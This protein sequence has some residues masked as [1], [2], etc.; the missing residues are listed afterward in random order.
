MESFS[1]ALDT[2]LLEQ[3]HK[4]A[5]SQLLLLHKMELAEATALT[6]VIQKGIN[7]LVFETDCKHSQTYSVIL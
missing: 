1:S 4:L 7:H 3:A 2:A 5:L 6:W